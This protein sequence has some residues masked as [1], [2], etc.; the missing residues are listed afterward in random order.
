MD[1]LDV[2]NADSRPRRG[3][4]AVR[5]DEL[6]RQV[7][8]QPGQV[9]ETYA[10]TNKKREVGMPEAIRGYP[11][12][13]LDPGVVSRA[14]DLGVD[15]VL[16]EPATGIAHEQFRLRRVWSSGEM[17]A[18]CPANGDITHCLTANADRA[19]RRIDIAP[20]QLHGLFQRDA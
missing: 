15:V 14:H 3:E 16:R 13:I 18:Q 12:C 4:Q 19:P 2:R 1:Q 5:A 7:T 8:D 11:I 9:G 17:P 6:H 10:L 20:A